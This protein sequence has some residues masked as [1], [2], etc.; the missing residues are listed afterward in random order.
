MIRGL[1]AHLRLLWRSRRQAGTSVKTA[2]LGRS[3]A[4]LS[5]ASFM[6]LRPTRLLA[7]GGLVLV[8]IFYWKPIHSYLHT[9]D[10]LNRRQAGGGKLQQQ[11]RRLQGR[12]ATVGQGDAL[13]REA[14]RLGL[15]KPGERLYIVRGISTWRKK[16]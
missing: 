15:V 16:H 1:A 11:Q 14:R 13:V 7:L 3:S 10:V 2:S 12:I 4:A 9:R 6:R 8:G 5:E